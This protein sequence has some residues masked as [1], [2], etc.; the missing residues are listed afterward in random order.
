MVLSRRAES[1]SELHAALLVLRSR[2]PPFPLRDRIREDGDIAGLGFDGRYREVECGLRGAMHNE[3]KYG[4]LED[5]EMVL[6]GRYIAETSI[7]EIIANI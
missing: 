1:D 3:Y 6:I 4:C 2:P 7:S 5:R